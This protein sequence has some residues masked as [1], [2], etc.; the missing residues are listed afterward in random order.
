M[1]PVNFDLFENVIEN[2]LTG[3]MVNYSFVLQTKVISWT[4]EEHE[5]EHRNKSSKRLIDSNSHQGNC[6]LTKEINKELGDKA[7]ERRAYNNLGIYYNSLGNFRKA[8]HCHELDIKIA[9]ELGDRA[10]EGVAYGNLGHNY[11]SVGD[12]E[13]AIHY[14]ELNL[15]I[16]KEVGDRVGEGVGYCNLGS[17][18]ANRADF[19]KAIYYYE[20]SVAIARDVGNRSAEG[21]AYANLGQ[22]Y[23]TLG[24]FKKAIHYHEL[25]LEIAKEVGNRV[26]VQ[27]SYGS[28]G[29]NYFN[30]RDFQNAIHYHELLLKSTKEEGDR[31]K[32]GAAYVNLGNDY[33]SLRDFKSAIH[34]AEL[35]LEIV[36][37]LGDRAEEGV[38]CGNIGNG[39]YSLGD[40]KT[41]IHY[42]NLF[43]EIAKEVGDRGKEGAAYGDLGSSYERLGDYKKAIH[44][45][46][47]ELAIGK[48]LGNRAREGVAYGNLGINYHRLGDFKKAVL[49]HNLDL[50]I[51]KEVRDRA[52]EGSAY[53][54]L[55]SSYE[56]LGDYKKAIHYHELH[57]EIAIELGNMVRKGAAYCY[58]GSDYHSLGNFE[59]AIH[60]HE[61][62]LKIA[63]QMGRRAEEGVAYGNLGNDYAQLRDFRKAIDYHQL[64]LEIA[65][66]VGD[67]ASEGNVYNSL[68]GDYLRL[69]EDEKA[70]HYLELA[71]DAFKKVGDR[72]QEGSAYANLGSGYYNLGDF[73]TSVYYHELCLKISKEVGNMAGEGIAYYLLG[74]SFESQ[75]SELDAVT[76]YQSS[77]RVLNDVRARL[78]FEDEFKISLRHQY[79]PMY[80][81]LWSGLLKLDKEVEALVAAEQGRTQ[82]LKDLMECKYGFEISHDVS[83]TLEEVSSNTFNFL[84]PNTVF[85]ALCDRQVFF[86]VIQKGK[87]V[88]LRS[89][90][91]SDN[92]SGD[93]DATSFFNSL[94][95][96]V[97][98][99]AQPGVKCEDRSLGKLRASVMA[100]DRPVE[101]GY[102]PLDFQSSALKKLHQFIIG[103]FEDLIHGDELIVVPEGPLW[104]APYAA[105]MVSDS[106]YLCDLFRIRLIP[107]LT[108]LKVIRDSPEDYHSECGALLVGDPWVQEIVV[109]D[110]G[111]KLMQLSSAKIEVEMIGRKLN[112]APLT[113]KEATKDEVLKRLSCVECPVALVHIAAHGCM[114]TGEIVLCPNPK[115]A[116]QIPKEKDFLLTIRD[117]LNANLRARLVVLSCCHSGRGEIKA[118]GVV[119]IARAFLGAGARSVL[120]SLWAIDDEAT[121]EFMEKF[122][123]H[124]LE[125]RSASESLN[126]AM[127]CMRNSHEFSEVKYWAPFA[128]IG[129]D[130]TLKFHGGD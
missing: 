12:S 121:L 36:K 51:A 53:G 67:R 97:F 13:K 127:K 115:R 122:Y 98:K 100:D 81:N 35:H 76:C 106:K 107:S 28:I 63:Q 26:E 55:G 110:K 22:A 3:A 78:Q 118:E 82:A 32:E 86:W 125:G 30:L 1:K 14:H 9:K 46:E 105:F 74:C 57:L 66:D 119:G 19:E 114:E 64:S 15:E 43:L 75:G 113:G 99:S 56:R 11:S 102:Y 111:E 60:Y 124:L 116:S 79:Q 95:N 101:T 41:A 37:Q 109:N 90:E 108:S 20:L 62:H 68:G 17:D 73:K 117:V 29:D 71:L 6:E 88:M 39:Y 61:L 50:E 31:S 27:S 72:A 47:L 18:Y 103:P 128:L 16:A 23:S 4:A 21:T 120:V 38:A 24:D 10:R 112:T 34:Y 130:V 77:V 69:R 58:L 84:P 59:K 126:R 44:Y 33:Q 42:H 91:I 7:T 48:E 54:N 96:I 40:F 87:D 129:D 104:L 93:H 2:V 49:Y 94:I 5:F 92:Q 123:Q 83:R 80:I 25:R 70:I 45:H 52:Q 8:I 89:K 65:K 85:T